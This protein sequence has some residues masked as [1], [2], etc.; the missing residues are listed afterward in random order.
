MNNTKYLHRNRKPEEVSGDS[1]EFAEFGEDIISS[2]ELT[3]KIYKTFLGMIVKGWRAS[4][5]ATSKSEF[6]LS[7]IGL[8]HKIGPYIPC[9]KRVAYTRG[10]DLHPDGMPGIRVTANTIPGDSLSVDLI[11]P[12]TPPKHVVFL[13]KPH[14]TYKFI[15]MDKDRETDEELTAWVLYFGLSKSGEIISTIN[16][17]KPVSRPWILHGA[18]QLYPS[19]SMNAWADSRYLWVAN[20]SEDI[21]YGSNNPL[22][23]RLGLS[24]EHIK[25]LFY[26]RSL[27]MTE[28]G[29]KRPILHWCRAHQRRIREGVDIDISAHLRGVFEFEMDGLAFEIT[30]PNKEAMKGTEPENV[31][32]AFRLYA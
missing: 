28:T 7:D 10:V 9:V 26:A 2:E 3:D 21:G 16:T 13:R 25:S 23:L 11:R 22:R 8:I 19:I 12:F 29:R 24:K 30:Q 20:T 5:N 27:P 31:R 14:K 4:D 18:Q 6:S 1:L 32:D 15:T 17:Q